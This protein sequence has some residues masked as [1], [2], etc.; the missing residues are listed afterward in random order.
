[1]KTQMKTKMEK[2]IK[3]VR[4]VVK[5]ASFESK[6]YKCFMVSAMIWTHIASNWLS[7]KTFQPRSCK[8][9]NK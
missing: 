8:V 6:L 7:Y 5:I 2:V 3:T 1:M 9:C 4:F